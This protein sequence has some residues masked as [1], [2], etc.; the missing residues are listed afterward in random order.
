MKG[1]IICK[2]TTEYLK[3]A[4]LPYSLAVMVWVLLIFLGSGYDWVLAAA[5]CSSLMFAAWGWKLIFI[6]AAKGRCSGL[7]RGLPASDAKQ[8][9]ARGLAAAVGVLIILA[10]FASMTAVIWSRI[11]FWGAQFVYPMDGPS[12]YYTEWLYEIYLEGGGVL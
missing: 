3:L 8:R 4:L 12:R 7:Y 6:D 10:G 1:R 11:E 5:I 2:L 9:T